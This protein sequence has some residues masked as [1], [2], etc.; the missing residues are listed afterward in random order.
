MDGPRTPGSRPVPVGEDR[1][2]RRP[3]CL[4]FDADAHLV[5]LGD[6]GAG[7]STL[8]CAVVAGVER[9]YAPGEAVFLLVDPR[10]GLLDVASSSRVLSWV[11]AR[12]EVH[13]VVR[14]VRA[15]M[16]LSLCIR[17]R[18]WWRGPELF[19][20]VDDYRML[21]PHQQ[22]NPL[23]PLV[24]LLPHGRDVGLHLVIARELDG[25]TP[26]ALAHDPLLAGVC[27]QGGPAVIMSGSPE[28]GPLLGGVV[29]SAQP[30]GQGVLVHPAEG[31]RPLAVTPPAARP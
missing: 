23:L 26:R 20:V 8:L 17:D 29:P 9:V 18:S 27:D 28:V 12:R 4:D 1:H 3:V 25:S 5:V 22:V 16:D 19:V 21:A 11:R 30:P 2:G 24:D 13:D 6:A 7:K 15:L 14:D 10:H 31:S